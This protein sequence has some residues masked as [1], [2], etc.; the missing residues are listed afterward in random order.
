MLFAL[1]TL[2][3]LPAHALLVHGAVVLVPLAALA[4]VATGWRASWRH[5]Y[6]F[7]CALL[8]GGGMVFA[9]LAQQTGGP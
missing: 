9:F 7:P 4:L 5:A 8:A 2:F 6:S 3:N 1:S